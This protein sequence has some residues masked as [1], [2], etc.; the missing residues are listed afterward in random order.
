M[1]HVPQAACWRC[2][3][4]GDAA[5]VCATCGA[6]QRLAPTTDLFQVLG[7]PRRLTVDDRQ[8]EARYHAAAR[9]I[10]PDRFQTADAQTQAVSVA[11]SALVNRAYR[12][13]RDPVARGRYWLELHG[14]RLADRGGAVPPA[15][16]AEVFETQE[17][18]AELRA[19]TAPEREVL[20]AEV[21]GLGEALA[22]RVRTL[23]A[24][25]GDRYA[26]WNG[27]GNR[28]LDELGERLAEIAYLTTLLGDIEDAM[29]EGL[30]GTHHRH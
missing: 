21:R 8:L 9:A 6:P 2:G 4:G 29:G 10:H 7:L 5:V 25:L 30:R 15:L 12:T 14:R 1:T 27:D 26:E 16:V 18:L 24:A 13:L 23:R 17:R 19:A 20:A 22:A 3:A 28:T 11:T